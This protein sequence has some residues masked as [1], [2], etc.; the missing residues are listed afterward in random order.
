MGAAKPAPRV[1]IIISSGVSPRFSFKH[2][3][4]CPGFLRS[5]IDWRNSMDFGIGCAI[6]D[7]FHS[8]LLSFTHFA[9]PFCKA[10]PHKLFL[11][12]ICQLFIIASVFLVKLAMALACIWYVRLTTLHLPCLLGC[13]MPAKKLGRCIHQSRFK[14]TMND[15]RPYYTQSASSHSTCILRVSWNVACICLQKALYMNLTPCLFEPQQVPRKQ[16]RYVYTQ[17]YTVSSGCSQ[18]HAMA[19]VDTCWH[20]I[21]QLLELSPNMQVPSQL[22]SPPSVFVLVYLVSLQNQHTQH[23]YQREYTLLFAS[24]NPYKTNQSPCDKTTCF[25]P[26]VLKTQILDLQCHRLAH[27]QSQGHSNTFGI[28]GTQ[29]HSPRVAVH[30]KVAADLLVSSV[31]RH[32]RKIVTKRS[33]SK[34]SR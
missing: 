7:C 20:N 34:P 26:N 28:G 6:I 27:I 10:E 31:Q 30:R 4:F 16:A 32:P 13:G 23:L 8:W 24:G 3:A 17:M 1:G 33:G 9:P 19:K 5:A 15:T 21:L 2:L 11:R 18:Q 25:S 22:L 29:A 12:Q 14:Q